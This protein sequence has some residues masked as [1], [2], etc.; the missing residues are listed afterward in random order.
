MSIT[1]WEQTARDLLSEAELQEIPDEQVKAIVDVLS[2]TI[3]ADQNVSPVEVAGFN[4]LFFDL[5]WLEERHELLRSHIPI[6]VKKAVGAGSEE[7]SRAIAIDVASKLIG[8]SL[9]EKVF[10]MASILASA[11]MRLKEGENKVLHMVADVFN[12]D[13]DR[14]DA[15]IQKAM[16]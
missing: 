3:H 1:S 16:P 4:H 2:L 11:D 5:P 7:D 10:L 14:R 15:I 8:D 9:R 6:S 13:E 12:I